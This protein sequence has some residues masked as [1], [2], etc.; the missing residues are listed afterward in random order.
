MGNIIRFSSFRTHLPSA[1]LEISDLQHT[2]DRAFTIVKV[3]KVKKQN[4]LGIRLGNYTFQVSDFYN[5]MVKSYLE[6]ELA[7][8]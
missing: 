6:L 2:L 7:T 1:V 5:V 8:L 4:G 3:R